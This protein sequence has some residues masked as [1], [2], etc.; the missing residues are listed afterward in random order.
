[1]NRLASATGDEQAMGILFEPAIA[2]LGKAKHPLDDPDR[3]LDPGP[4][5]RLGAV[6]RPLDLVDNTAVGVAAISEIP[7]LGRA[8][9]DYRRWLR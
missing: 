2:Q 9:P 8:L 3:M 5:F 1:M 6:F 4:H 7:G